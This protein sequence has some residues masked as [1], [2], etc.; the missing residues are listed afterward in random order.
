MLIAPVAAPIPFCCYLA[1]ISTAGSGNITWPLSLSVKT[2]LRLI[3]H[4]VATKKR[5]VMTK[6]KS[7]VTST[8]SRHK[9]RR[10][11]ARCSNGMPRETQS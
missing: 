6:L 9:R 11:S 1:T 8:G 7:V 10:R 2:W 5:Y 3:A 4:S